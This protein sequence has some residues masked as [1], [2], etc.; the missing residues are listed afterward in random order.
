MRTLR[1]VIMMMILIGATAIVSSCVYDRNSYPPRYS[2]PPVH[3]VPAW[4]WRMR[5]NNRWFERREKEENRG[6]Q[7]W[8]NCNTGERN[9]HKDR[10]KDLNNRFGEFPRS[11][12]E[13]DERHRW[14]GHRDR[15]DMRQLPKIP[16]P[17]VP[18]Q[19]QRQPHI[20]PPP[21]GP[22]R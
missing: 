18:Q 7:D 3:Q 6:F 16:P 19:S 11:R 8:I 4:E 22:G 15:P 2:S 17:R 20:P 21:G 12:H 13:R 14:G 10:C 5:P 9:G 1:N